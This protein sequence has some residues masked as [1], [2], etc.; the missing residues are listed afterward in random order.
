MFY[1]ILEHLSQKCIERPKQSISSIELKNSTSFQQSKS[2]NDYPTVGGELDV[3]ST[4]H[5]DLVNTKK[6]L[7]LLGILFKKN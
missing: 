3:G 7:F 6:N 2:E 1:C 5:R 4:A